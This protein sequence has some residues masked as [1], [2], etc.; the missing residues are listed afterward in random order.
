[1]MDHGAI[2]SQPIAVIGMGCRLPGADNLQQYWQLI[3]EG[4]STVR[5]LPAERFDRQLYF[6]PDKGVRGKSYSDVACTIDYGPRDASRPPLPEV[7][8]NCREPVYTALFDVASDAL[9]HAGIDPTRDRAVHAG[10]YLGHTRDGGLAGD[11]VYGTYI[12]EAAA[13]LKRIPEL[14]Q[15]TSGH[16]EQVVRQ[17]VEEVHAEYPRRDS[18]GGPTLGA[19]RAAGLL[20]RGF[21]FTGPYMAFNSACAS[22][23]NALAQAVRALQLGRI[24][25]ALVGGASYCHHDTFVTFSQAQSLTANVSRPFDAGADGLVVGEGYAM[26]VL[27]TLE[28]AITDGDPIQAVI[29]GVGISADGRGSSLWAPRREGQIEAVRR[30]YEGNLDGGRV[31]YIEAHATS[32]Q[33]GDATE[34]SA[35]A[36]VF[37]E[38]VPRGAKIPLGS[39]KAQIGHTLEAA[40]L[41][42]LLKTVLCMQNQVLPAAGHVEQ[43]NPKI[44]WNDVPFVIPNRQQPWLRPADGPRRAAVNAFGIG[45]LN[46]HVVLD[47]HVSELVSSRPRRLSAAPTARTEATSEDQTPIAVIGTGAVLPGARSVE[48]LWNLFA[49]GHDPKSVPPNSR[50]CPESYCQSDSDGP[51]SFQTRVG[52]FVEGFEYDWRLHKIPPK[53]IANAS[54]LQFMILDAVEQALGGAGYDGA[55]LNRQR[56]GAIVGNVFGGEFSNQLLVGLRLPEFQARLARVLRSHGATDQ[57]IAD[58]ARQY[59]EI[60]LREM[61]AMLDETGSFTS[62]SLASRITKTFNLMGGAVAVDAGS[63][64]SGAALACCVDL[65]QSGDCETMLCVGGQEDLSP[66]KFAYWEAEGHLA[67]DE[68]GR[69]PSEGCGVLLLKRLDDARRDG[70]KILGIIR[71]I[72]GASGDDLRRATRLA[73]EHAFRQTSVEPTEVAAIETT[74]LGVPQRD[75]LER[76]GLADIYPHDATLPVTAHTVQLGH[77]MSAAGVTAVLKAVEELQHTEVP[78]TFVRSDSTPTHNP[79]ASGFITNVTSPTPLKPTDEGRIFMAVHET[80]HD[81][82]AYHILIERG[83][84][85][86]VPQKRDNDNTGA[87]SAVPEMVD[88]VMLFDATQVRKSKMRQQAQRPATG[89]NNGAPQ[90]VVPVVEPPAE[91]RITSTPRI[92]TP[93]HRTNGQA[94]PSPVKATAPPRVEST[95]AKPVGAALEPAELETFLINF[96]VEQ[97]GYPPEIV[98]MDADLEADLGIDSIKKAQLFGELREYFDITPDEN[99]TLDDFP[100]LRDIQQYLLG[101]DSAASTPAEP[102]PLVS[103]P[104]ESTSPAPTPVSPPPSE[105]LDRAQLE[106]FLVNFVVEQ[107]GYPPEIVEMDADLE[108]DLGIDSIKKAQLFGELREYF[109]I[110]PDE[111]LT[112]DDF[113]SL[114][115]IQQYLLQ[116]DFA[117]T[118]SALPP[119]SAS[120]ETAAVSSNT[121]NGA[122]TKTVGPAPAEL[123][124]FLVNFVVEQTGY[125]PEIVEMDADLEADLGIDSI[126]KAQLF[127]ELREYFDI[128]LEENESLS[129]DDFP[130]LRHIQHFLSEAQPANPSPAPV[131]A[132]SAVAPSNGAATSVATKPSKSSQEMEAFL[133]NFVVEQTGYPPEIVEMDADLEADLGIDSIKKAQLFGEL[134]EYFD[135][136]LEDNESLSLDEFPTL[137]HV[138]D[139]LRDK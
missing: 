86:S 5:P 109:D 97:T 60:V 101:A 71:G 40:G 18:D 138:A 51:W 34:I 102:A 61:P 65:L 113:P 32:T 56:T 38:W 94:T 9:S 134:R 6:H 114:R 3:Q 24:E 83:S 69:V 66:A 53:Q 43:L 4:R 95:P 93:P 12:A 29:R 79:D 25:M 15:L 123:E 72:A 13:W 119:N 45:G 21:G 26:V 62:S 11:L 14:N 110:M 67:D 17:I 16:A 92:A 82:S 35:L 104:V 124:S 84:P 70:D 112:L 116:A 63:A 76:A 19:S 10:V 30:A 117:A 89:N 133:V 103:V 120:P 41:S 136:A 54:P 47:E 55:S 36:E 31:Q 121:S 80:N 64:S 127:G 115:D 132:T 50:L 137:Q 52:G 131:V 107:T 130:T 57:Q 74:S 125:P 39:V 85:V 27:K 8:A 28:Q 108:A 49:E 88:G 58:V 99:L 22:S 75:Q 78:A 98:E 2:K 37:K 126:K 87:G 33:L 1:M 106:S 73:A 91:T 7:F 44:D 77:G 48:A 59:E 42:G 111:N 128:A 96:V 100:T 68:S 122:A 90:P 139:F 46:V 105:N 118:S 81:D 23:L 129:L 20:A 135:I